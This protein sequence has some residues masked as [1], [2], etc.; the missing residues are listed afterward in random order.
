VFPGGRVDPG[1]ENLPPWAGP[2]PDEWGAWLGCSGRA[3]GAIV[4][5]AVRELFE[6]SGVLLVGD[7][8]GRHVAGC[9]TPDWARDRARLSTHAATLADVLTERGMFLRSDLLGIRGHW[10][11]PEFEPRRYD[12]YFFTALLPAGQRADGGTTE[13]VSHQWVQPSAVLASAVAAEVLLLPP[14][15]CSIAQLAACDE[16]E[17]F[18][19][20]RL[21]VERTMFVP[22][23]QHDDSIALSCC[24]PHSLRTDALP[25]GGQLQK[26]VNT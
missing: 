24:L 11:T 1:D 7:A 26:E 22:T 19:L 17:A 14:T 10:L 20:T 2:T 21:A 3:A 9:D 18:A 25:A 23:V 13:A 6:E 12:T 15:A 5:A 16:V 4:T 8:D